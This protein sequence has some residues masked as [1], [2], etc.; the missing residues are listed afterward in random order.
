LVADNSHVLHTRRARQDW[1]PQAQKITERKTRETHAEERLDGPFFSTRQFCCAIPLFTG[2]ANAQGANSEHECQE[3]LVAQEKPTVN[4]PAAQSPPTSAESAV[5]E[6]K[7]ETEQSRFR[8]SVMKRPLR[9]RVRATFIFHLDRGWPD[10]GLA[11][12][13]ARHCGQDS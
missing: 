2:A 4:S 5:T 13:A 6:P 8:T 10:G 1:R 12:F 11:F 3:I 9:I 7:T